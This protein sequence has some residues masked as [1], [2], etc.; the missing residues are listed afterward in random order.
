M[1]DSDLSRVTTLANRQ[2]GLESEI[3]TLEK[4]LEAKNK[5]LVKLCM[6]D[7]PQ[8]MTD[9]GLEALSLSNGASLEMKKFYSC[10]V[11]EKDPEKK[12]KALR[13]LRKNELGSLIK[14]H[15][16]IE[17]GIDSD[18][19]LKST[20]GFLNRKSI[21]F[22]ESDSVNAATLK[23]FMKERME[24]GKEFPLD[25]FSGYVG[26]KTVISMPNQ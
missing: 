25:I 22:K 3:A 6:T 24:A 7:L 9:V 17:L 19:I 18:L 16:K 1:T 15:L 13:W 14:R 11:A 10:S 8:A 23:A 26:K 5:E 20:R 21:P 4:V 2:I 12:E